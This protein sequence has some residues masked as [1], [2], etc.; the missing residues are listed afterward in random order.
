LKIFWKFPPPPTPL[1]GGMET[2]VLTVSGGTST[3]RL[4]I[5]D[6]AYP[7]RVLKRYT[8]LKFLNNLYENLWFPG[9]GV[10]DE[11]DEGRRG[12]TLR[13][14]I[15]F[16]LQPFEIQ[17]EEGSSSVFSSPFPGSNIRFTPHCEGHSCGGLPSSYQRISLLYAHLYSSTPRSPSPLQELGRRTP[18]SL[19]FWLEHQEFS[20][21]SFIDMRRSVPRSA[22]PATG[23][24]PEPHRHTL[25]LLQ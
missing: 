20:A 16:S 17:Y 2:L 24:P 5:A 22:Q 18:S 3:K 6:R 12:K 25:F 19:W 4:R 7:Q 15:A 13:Y 10:Y 9:K 21:R 14:I 8:G 23:P 11:K 1:P